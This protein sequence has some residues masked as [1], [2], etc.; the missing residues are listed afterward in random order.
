MKTYLLIKD[1]KLL[2]A[3]VPDEPKFDKGIVQSITYQKKQR[4]QA[5]VEAIANALPVINPQVFVD[6]YSRGLGTFKQNELIAWDGGAEVEEYLGGDPLEYTSYP[7]YKKV[8]RLSLEENQ[9]QLWDEV[10]SIM[11][12]PWEGLTRTKAIDDVMK[13]FTLTRK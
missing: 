9:E 13:E 4:E 2:C 8:V 3:F 6:F 11:D 10:A 7:P 12:L 5:K 1:G